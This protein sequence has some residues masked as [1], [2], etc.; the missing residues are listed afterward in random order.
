MIGYYGNSGSCDASGCTPTFS[1]IPDAYNVI[2]MTFLNIDDSHNLQFQISSYAPVQLADLAT[3][4][5]NWK[6]SADP[7][8]RRKMVLVSL[9]GQNGH[10]PATITD[11]EVV[12]KLGDF[13]R[14]HNL[15]GLDIDFESSAIQFVEK[16]I[17]AFL[18]LKSEG[19]VLSAA[20][21]AAQG[22]LTAYRPILADLDWVHPQFYNNPPNAVTVPFV[23][24]FENQAT[25]QSPADMP[26]WLVTMD[27]TANLV[28]MTSQQRGIAIPA[29]PLAAG[30]NNQ[31]DLNLLAAQIRVG[32]IRNVATWA[33]G[34]D[35]QNGWAL[36]NV[37]AALND[38]DLTSTTSTSSAIASTDIATTTTSTSTSCVDIKPSSE[39][40]NAD[41]I[42]HMCT[43]AGV[44]W[45]NQCKATCN[46]C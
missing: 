33:L 2:I 14:Q 8:G 6:S 37:I 23:P 45:L 3:E 11:A 30:N 38:Q 1:E 35:K 32:D 41:Q 27:T 18:Q 13:M 20:P 25:W 17:A 26:W 31:W 36:A 4:I 5:T 39:C 16:N 34:Y 19:F 44:W 46:Q 21:E 43:S 29:T 9:G 28:G 10:W 42:W 40:L 7:W 24:Q 15:D 22:P 12:T